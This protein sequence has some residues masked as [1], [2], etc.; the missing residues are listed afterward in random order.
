MLTVL[1]WALIPAAILPIV[2]AIV[3]SRYRKSSSQSLRDRFYLAVVLA[4]LGIVAALVALTV[5]TDL[6]TGPLWPIFAIALL[7][8]DVVSG[9]WL[10]DYQRGRFR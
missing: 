8:A 5:V 7:A 3:L 6:R 4:F 1:A 10:L 9:K 2:T